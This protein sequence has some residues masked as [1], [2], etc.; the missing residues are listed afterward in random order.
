LNQVLLPLHERRRA[1][2]GA[3]LH[4]WANPPFSKWDR[5]D[6]TPAYPAELPLGVFAAKLDV[7]T[8]VLAAKL[9]ARPRSYRA[10]R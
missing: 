2:I 5:G 6:T 4:P 1:E 3:H 9:G 10:G 8:G 7:L